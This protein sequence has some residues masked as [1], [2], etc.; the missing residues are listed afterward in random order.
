MK[1]LIFLV[2]LLILLV[3]PALTQGYRI[4]KLYS[5][6]NPEAKVIFDFGGYG[7]AKILQ[8]KGEWVKVK[9]KSKK[10]KL[11]FTSGKILF[12][13]TIMGFIPIHASIQ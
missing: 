8:R 13:K 3:S 12:V 6:P 10:S 5:G 7:E 2:I 4:S 1:Q 9:A 11:L